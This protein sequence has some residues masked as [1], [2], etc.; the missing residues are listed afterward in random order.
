MAA[1]TTPP[2]YTMT[3][4]ANQV[5]LLLNVVTDQYL[6]GAHPLTDGNGSS[7]AW[8]VCDGFAQASRGGII[9]RAVAAGLIWHQEDSERRN[10]RIEDA[11]TIGITKAG[12]EAICAHFNLDSEALADSLTALEF[13]AQ[14]HDRTEVIEAT[15]V[16]IEAPKDI[17]I[18]R[19]EVWERGS[20][21]GNNE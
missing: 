9:S 10:G 7:W 17:E 3:L 4:T 21:G 18:L 16:A 11:S 5:S 12:W 20:A 8:S 6:D 13:I 15:T 2:E 19:E 1:D 14:D